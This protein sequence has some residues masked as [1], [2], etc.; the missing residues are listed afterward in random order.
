MPRGRWEHRVNEPVWY[1]RS[2]DRSDRFARLA[3][4]ADPHDDHEFDDELAIV[5]ALRELGSQPALDKGGR[6]RILAAIEAKAAVA[7][8]DDEPESA[9]ATRADEPVPVRTLHGGGAITDQQRRRAS[10]LA[11]ATAAGVVAIGA[12]GIELSQT[13]IPGDLLYDLKRTTESIALDLTFS[14]EG[15][16]REHIEIAS[17]R[18]E[19]L[20]GL[21][22]RDNADGGVTAAEVTEYR[23]LLID[24]NQSAIAASRVITMN[25]PDSDTDNED[26]ALLREW[27]TRASARMASLDTSMP[28]EVRSQFGRSSDLM[29]RIENRAD[30]L[31]TRSHCTTMA[32]NRSDVIGPLPATG[33]CEPAANERQQVAVQ[34]KASTTTTGGG[35]SAP[36]TAAQ[37]PASNAPAPSTGT[38]PSGRSGP[39]EDPGDDPEQPVEVPKLPDAP[40]PSGDGPVAESETSSTGLPLLPDLGIG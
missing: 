36:D 20:T 6:A 31:L 3:D 8:A 4:G 14:D 38:E 5:S 13:A 18:I 25:A 26:L 9:T 39:T 33:W 16:A 11:A 30:A 1:R 29:Q 35:T 12:L 21:V 40:L 23:T 32:S 17:T 37:P 7:V 10:L 22:Q 34:P 19:E 24:L 28:D 15:K 2:K 27:A